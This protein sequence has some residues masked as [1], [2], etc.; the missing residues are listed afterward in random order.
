MNCPSCAR[1]LELGELFCP[2]CGCPT[3][4]EV[5]C[6]TAFGLPKALRIDQANLEQQYHELSRRLHPDRF[7]TRP[8][9]VR[10]ASLKATALLTRSY[11]TLRDPLAR[12]IY[13]LS[14]HGVKLDENNRRVPSE[15]AEMVF[16]VQEELAELR[17]ARPGSSDWSALAA[18]M[19]ERR[20]QIG[21]LER[22]AR[23]ELERNFARSDSAGGDAAELATELKETLARIAYLRTLARDVERELEGVKAA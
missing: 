2:Y 3:G 19:R 18:R 7:A 6:F 12:A 8:A 1:Q 4:A 5:D 16:E 20:V 13:W 17:S 9:A 21:E 23:E 15:L 10:D 14:L 22:A 11:R